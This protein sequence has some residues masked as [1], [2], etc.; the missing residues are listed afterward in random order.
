MSR[1]RSCGA[2]IQWVPTEKGKLNP[3]EPSE[4]GNIALQMEL[5]GSETAVVVAA[6][7][8]T[9]VSHFATC[10]QAAKWRNRG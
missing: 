7:T 8:G 2:E 1:C 10:P 3:I 9:H 5:D 6:G 4:G